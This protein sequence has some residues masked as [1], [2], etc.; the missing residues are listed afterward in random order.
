MFNPQD[1]ISQL[2]LSGAGVPVLESCPSSV[3][4]GILQKLGFNT[5]QGMPQHRTDGPSRVSVGPPQITQPRKVLTAA[6]SC[7]GFSY[8][9][10]NEGVHTCHRAHVRS[11]K[12]VC[13]YRVV[14]WDQ[15]HLSVWQQASLHQAI[16]LA[17]GSAVPT[18]VS[19]AIPTY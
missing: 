8:F 7:L 10:V 12:L 16:S 13:S 18:V 4:A 19:A 3:C 2:S 5:G 15:L 1:W 14:P 17:P 11:D 6:P 9:C